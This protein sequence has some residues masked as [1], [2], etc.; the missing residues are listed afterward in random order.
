MEEELEL[1]IMSSSLQRLDSD[2]LVERWSRS[3]G[4]SDLLDDGFSCGFDKGDV[5]RHTRYNCDRD[6]DSPVDAGYQSLT[7]L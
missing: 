4:P 6:E 5:N 3:P 1:E 7:H 2:P